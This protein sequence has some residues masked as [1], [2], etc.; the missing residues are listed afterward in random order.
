MNK[1]IRKYFAVLDEWDEHDDNT[2]TDIGSTL[3]NPDDCIDQEEW[4][5]IE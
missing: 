4:W 2:L 3:L 1:E 5:A